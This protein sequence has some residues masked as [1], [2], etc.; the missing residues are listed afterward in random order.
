MTKTE[1][2][3]VVHSARVISDGVET[4][5]GWVAWQG[6]RILGT[7]TGDTWRAHAHNSSTVT[8]AR[9]GVLTPGFIDIHGHGG[10][11]FSY[12]DGADAIRAARTAHRAHGT[13]RA[14]ISLVTAPLG[15]LA[16]RVALVAALSETD[17]DILGSHLEGPFLEHAHKG[18]HDPSLLTD[19][20]AERIAMLLDAGSGTVRQV[21][22]APELIGGLDAVRQI[23]AAGA[24]AGAAAAVGHTGATLDQTAAAFD[25]GATILTHAFNAMPGLHHR[26]PG[27]I[28]A[29]VADR[30]I[31]LEVIADGVHVHPQMVALAF[32][33]APGRIALVT[34]AM[35][36]AAAS[37]GQYVLGSLEVTVE[38]GVA[39]L[40]DGTIAGST[41]TQDAAVRT[42]V[43][44]GVRLVDAIAA[45]TSTP[46][47][48]IGYADS[49]GALTPG[50]LADAV[51][52]NTDLTVRAVW[53]AGRPVA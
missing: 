15:L 22:L 42:A 49:L 16:E 8:D 51:L 20:T 33:A 2:V 40:G 19:A 5:N 53:C 35:A 29:A 45:V 13:T 12:D 28:G 11:G 6:E 38:D 23:V 52:L 36:G 31:T 39:R 37:D 48:A 10:G 21:T 46:A 9:G 14:V 41:L 44:A 24:A 4:R 3:S 47:R 43:S 32:A 17:D 50:F 26:E 18:A 25:A 1:H 30:R 27:P 7:G 34:D